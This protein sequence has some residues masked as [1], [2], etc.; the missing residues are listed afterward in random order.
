MGRQFNI[1]NP[2]IA[3]EVKQSARAKRLSLRVSRLDGKISLTMPRFASDKQA[4]AFLEDRE[5][6]MRK[7]LGSVEPMRS[8]S[9]GGSVPFMGEDLPVSGAAVKRAT[10]RDGALLVPEDG[11]NTGAKVQA[12][13]KLAARDA[14]SVASD[15]YSEKIGRSYSRI[16]LRDTKSRWGSCSHQ[17]VLM[18]SWRLIMAP[19][20]VLDYVAAHEVAHLAEMNHSPAFWSV[21]EGLMPNYKIH[22][23]WLKQNGSNLHRVSFDD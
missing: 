8:V 17:G 20:S 13:L 4:R 19:P 22:R 12:F 15:E 18:Y 1:G 14:L 21:V 16:S 7:H 11:K 3:V 10:Y 2:P 23:K 9:I 6:W 5:D